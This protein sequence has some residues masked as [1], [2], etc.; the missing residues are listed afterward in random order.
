[1]CFCKCI[2]LQR[3][4]KLGYIKSAGEVFNMLSNV[5]SQQ[6]LI[7]SEKLFNIVDILGNTSTGGCNNFITTPSKKFLK[8]RNLCLQMNSVKTNKINC[9]LNY[10]EKYLNWLYLYFCCFLWQAFLAFTCIN[11]RKIIGKNCLHS[12]FHREKK[13]EW[14]NCLLLYK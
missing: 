11:C 4:R 3:I 14:S 8:V 6:V 7:C 1:M 12:T 13:E 2:V 5:F 10:N 9:T